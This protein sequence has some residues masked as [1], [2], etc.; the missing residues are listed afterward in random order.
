MTTVHRA[1][2]LFT[3]LYELT[4]AAS[5]YANRVFAPATFSL[6]IRPYRAER[7]FFVAAGLEQVLDELASFRF[8]A[9][10]LNYLQ[11]TGRFA[12]DFLAY[13]TQLR[14]SGQ[15]YALPEGTIFFADEPV[16][17]I[18]APIIEA[19]LLET[20][21][22]NTVGF[23]TMI[24]S[25][26]ARCFHA[27]AGRPLI[28]F[29]L[30][31][32]QGRDAGIK[33]ARST[34]LAG[35]EGTSNVLAGKIYGIPV[36]GTMAHSYISAFDSELEA[37]AAYADTFPNHSIFLIDTYNTLA[38]AQN[39]AAVAKEMKQR[40]QALIG[41][42]LDSGDMAGL[43]RKVRKILDD[44]GLHAV[45]I[46]AS[47]G[48]DEFKI[49]KVVSQ[50]ARIDA[51]GVGTKV[52]VSA[53]APYVD[54]VYKMVRFNKRNV[55]KLSPGKSTLAGEKQVF[56]KS[57]REGRYLEDIIG[58]RNE[59]MQDGRPL[60]EK[61]MADGK[62]LRAHPALQAVQERFK[63]NFSSLDDRYKSI[64]DHIAYPV[65]LSRRLQELQKTS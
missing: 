11:T 26:A 55:R 51:F 17:E 41:V 63:K 61:V 27:A 35:F 37:F 24:A 36:S 8:S 38:G 32:T 60:L 25:K 2:P 23:Q 64:E 45:K 9:Q 3:D 33:V 34:F 12:A 7:N 20:F 57:D 54:I 43:S 48:F 1:G 46:F 6:Y 47:S 19:Q 58:L 10:D 5:Y 40:G 16:I 14:F 21:L 65:K 44:A 4:M 56:R 53:D 18:T 13:L 62:I 49:A 31:R 29:S 59:S 30:R 22:L 28:D 50:G 39:A 15:V 42:R 52:G